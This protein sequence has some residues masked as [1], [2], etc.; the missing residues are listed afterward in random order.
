MQDAQ[1]LAVGVLERVLAGRNFDAELAACW[2][3]LPEGAQQRALVQDLC[4][5]VLRHLGPLDAVLEPLLAKPLRDERLRHLLRI[6]LYQL[7]HTKAAPH[8][9]VDQ[10]VRACIALHAAPAKGLVNAVLRGFLRRKAELQAASQRDDVGRYSY[11]QWWIDKMRAQYSHLSPQQFADVLL[12]GNQHAPLTLRVNPRRIARDDYLQQLADS[13]IPATAL[14]RQAVVLGKP[15]PVHKLP[16]FSEGQ[17]SVQDASAQRAA[18]LLDVH[19]GMRVLDACAAPGGKAAHVLELADVALTALDQDATRLQ[20]VSANLQRLGLAANVV[21]GDAADPR[22]W[23]DG[24]PFERILAD[25]PCSASGVTRRHPDIKWS[26]RETDIAQFV[27]QQQAVI[28]ALWRLLAAGGKFLYVTCSVFRE[29]NHHQVGR[30]LERHAD[31]Q[32]LPLPADEFPAAPPQLAGQ[33]LPDAVH[34]GF[35]YALLQ[36][37]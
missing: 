16:G 1:V 24:V 15:M 27:A 17:V 22:A 10:A 35:Y 33:I 29:E 28:D 2:R 32:P 12:A 11:P 34:D 25:V 6:A 26:R 19:D 31:A 3:S 20:R 30:F 4:Y 37:N 9:V 18:P 8:A 14:E 36:K 23:W 5:G 13:G 7:Q 21:C